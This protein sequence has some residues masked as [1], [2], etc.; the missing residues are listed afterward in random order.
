MREI[1]RKALEQIK[2]YDRLVCDPTDSARQTQI[3]IAQKYLTEFD[4]F[5]DP[6]NDDEREIL[7]IIDH[8]IE[9]KQHKTGF[10]S[11]KYLQDQSDRRSG[12]IPHE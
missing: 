3:S 8:W 12:D 7:I 5:P 11:E 9:T 2:K 1:Y 10:F 4:L 6:I